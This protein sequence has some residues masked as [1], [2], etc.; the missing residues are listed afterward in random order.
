MGIK[1]IIIPK[2]NKKDLENVPKAVKSKIKF[3]IAD[4]VDDELQNALIGEI[5][6][7]N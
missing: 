2:D 1:T 4:K 5:E 3:I 6:H 7:G